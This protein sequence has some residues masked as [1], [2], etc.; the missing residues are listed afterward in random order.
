[1][2]TR[3]ANN[4]YCVLAISVFL[5]A[6][7]N[8][9]GA[10]A[11]D[12]L[13]VLYSA[14][15]LSQSMPWI[16]EAAGLLK[17]YDLDMELVYVGGGPRAAAATIA[18]DTGVTVVGGV[19]IVR[20]F[21]QGN[22]DLAFIGSVKNILTHSIFAKPDIKKP[23]NLRKKRIGDTQIGSNPHY[24]AVQAL[25]H[26]GIEARE[27]AFIQTGGTAET[28]AA[29]VAKGVDAAVLLPPIDAQAIDLGYHYVINGPELRIPYA[30][31]TL[32]TR[33]SLIAER[34][35]VLSRVMRVMAE[36]AMILH[37]DREFTY[38]VLGKQLRLT[39]RKILDAAYNAEIKAL[40]PRLVFKPEALQAILDEVAE[41][42][43][44]AKKIKPQDL[45]DTRFLDE[46]E[47]SGFFDQLWSG[48]R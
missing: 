14:R 44:R 15:S 32:V 37:T 38:K 18:G 9:S 25:R 31:T 21:V 4:H 34:Q 42:D 40:E 19:S 8:Y 13:V 16:A 2:R 48:K 33:R 12:R 23:E 22:K 41:I 11:A 45:V 43:S 47:K 6:V 24:F 46:M 20:P 17:K 1:M 10:M 26:F 29:L 35:R 7:F 27:V 3:L 36:A 5:A 30:A 28:L 39:D